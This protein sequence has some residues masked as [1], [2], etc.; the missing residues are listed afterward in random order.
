MGIRIYYINILTGVKNL[1]RTVEGISSIGANFRG[2]DSVVESGGLFGVWNHPMANKITY[3][4]LHA[5]QHRG[6]T[7][8][9]IVTKDN[10]K[11]K[12][13]RGRGLISHVFDSEDKLEKLTGNSAIGQ[14]RSATV[15]DQADDSNIQP[16]LFH[17]NNQSIAITHNGNLTDALSL[18]HQL[19][20]DGAVFS[21][22]S[23]AEIL[24]HIIRRSKEANFT[25][26]FENSIK[27]LNGGFN[28]CLL[29]DDALYGAVDKHGFRPLIIGQF[30][31]GAY[32]LAS[33]TC[34]LSSVGAKYVTELKAGQYVVINDEGY[35][36]NDYIDDAQTALEPMEFIYFSRPDSDIAGINVHTA[37]KEM[38]RRLAQEQPAPTADLVIG[39]PNSSLSSASGY[40]E[41]HGLPYE[42]GLIKHQYI[43]RTFIQPNQELREQ[44]VRYKLSVVESLIR[45]KSI[46]LVDDSIVRGTTVRHLVQLLE[47]SGAKEVHLRIASPPIRFPNY[48]GINTTHTQELVA[49]N[50]TVPELNELFGCDSLGYL[51]IQGLVDSINF[52]STV[53]DHGVSL[54]AYTGEYPSDIGDY[55]EEFEESLTPLQK[56]ILKGEF[57][58]E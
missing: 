57:H 11:F 26:A 39:V 8:A 12:S 5:L 38:G 42:I 55:Q 15:S 40:A 48:Y 50:Y 9:G 1:I 14:V 22:N 46:V 28:F 20:N 3:F 17:F 36:I 35:Q 45:N 4:G 44:G 34:V 27:Q 10:D 58:D 51:S 25:K 6:Q 13:Y 56:K 19:E 16:L 21:T 31:N 43:G 23:A 49:A 18:R 53:E 30:A 2:I 47:D 54:D 52:D 7:S 41:E 32:I 37:R 33:E 24:I 29:T